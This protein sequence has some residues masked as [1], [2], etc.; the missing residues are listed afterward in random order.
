MLGRIALLA[1]VPVAASAALLP[2]ALQGGGR[3]EVGRTATFAGAE[4][5][6]LL[7]SAAL[8]QWEHRRGQCRRQI[9]E[10][11]PRRTRVS[12]QCADG[13]FGTSIIETI[14]P[15][16]VRIQTQGIANGYPFSYVIHARRTGNCAA[17]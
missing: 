15:R 4:Q 1:A 13:G 3:W 9:L 8:A 16:S 11:G 6:C 14:T 2:P 17:H 7:D 12:Y 5:V 10:S